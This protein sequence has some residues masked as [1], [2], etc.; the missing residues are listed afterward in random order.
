MEIKN[1]T[2]ELRKILNKI[3]SFKC[4]NRSRVYKGVLEEVF[5]GQILVCGD[6]F[7]IRDI[8]SVKLEE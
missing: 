6:W 1:S 7:S 5:R 3:I 2:P 4:T 8:Y